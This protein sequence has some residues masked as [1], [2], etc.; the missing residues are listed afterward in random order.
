[1][2][3]LPQPGWSPAFARRTQGASGELA[4]ILALAAGTGMI[5]FAGGLPDPRTFPVGVLAELTKRLL[6]GDAAVSLQY[7]PTPGLP[8]L[9]QAFGDRLA[10]TEGRRPQPGELMV[11]SGTIDA[12]GLLAKALIDAGDVVAVE[13]PTYLGAIDGF[14]GFQAD[15]RGIPVD[16]DGVDVAAFERLCAS[17]APPKLLYTIPDHQNPTGITMSAERRTALVEV[18]RKHGVLLVEDVAYRELSFTADRPPTLWSLAPDVVVQA[19]TTSKTFFPGVRL[20][21]AVGP[22]E[23][24]AQ[25][26]IAKQNS[27]QCAGAFGQRLLEEYLR[28]HHLDPQLRAS[29]ALYAGRC[30]LMLAALD[31]YMPPAITW[32]RP[33]GGFFTWLSGPEWLDTTALA[34]RARDAGLAFVPGR[35]FH[36]TGGGGNQLRLAYSLAD[37]G[38]IIEGVRRLGTL[39][40]STMENR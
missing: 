4:A 26:V 24:I 21:W 16:E 33:R 13:A 12:I 30:H 27:D 28:G 8:G 25:M 17:N 11:T 9:R 5:S 35:P 20:G 3:T 7:S 37:D 14:R 1:M 40:R 29:R 19:G 15:I 36:P 18:C 6:A 2:A 34:R 23:V 38:Q 39:I 32:T 22:A 10:H 31:E